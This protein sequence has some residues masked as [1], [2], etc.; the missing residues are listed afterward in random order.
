MA[1]LA[2]HKKESG[3]LG[4]QVKQEKQWQDYDLNKAKLRISSGALKCLIGLLVLIF[5]VPYIADCLNGLVDSNR[6]SFLN[7]HAD[8]AMSGV[9][10]LITLVFGY[11]A[12]AQS[13][14]Q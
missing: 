5:L 10:S 1:S 13:S 4:H 14:K 12:G 9:I 7:S 8:A 6:L 2:T 3:E 11:I